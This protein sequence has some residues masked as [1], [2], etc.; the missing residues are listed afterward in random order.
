[1]QT[2]KGQNADQRRSRRKI[3]IRHLRRVRMASAIDLFE[4]ARKR[5]GDDVS[6]QNVYDDLRFMRASGH[7]SKPFR[8]LY[9]I[10]GAE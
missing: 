2:K 8:G 4:A 9:M 3:I 10:G 1:M 6:Y 5:L 7:I